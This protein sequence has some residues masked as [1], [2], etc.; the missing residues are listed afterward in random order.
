MKKQEELKPF[1][2]AAKEILRY[3]VSGLVAWLMSEG[4]IAGLVALFGSGMKPEV[5]LLFVTVVSL[6]IRGIDKYVHANPETDSK[7]VIPF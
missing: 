4:V 5:Q 6:I 3:V 2:E 1:P 7:G